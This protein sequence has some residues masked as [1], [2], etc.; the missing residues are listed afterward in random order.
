MLIILSTVLLASCAPAQVA[1]PSASTAPPAG[2]PTAAV[3]ASPVTAPVV[4][5]AASP[6]ASKVA[7]PAWPGSLDRATETL[8]ELLN[9][10]PG[11]RASLPQILQQW[12]PSSS[13]SAAPKNSLAEADLTGDGRPELV[14]GLVDP[15]AT[16]SPAGP[17]GLVIAIHDEGGR[18][19]SIP[20]PSSSTASPA[21]GPY[22]QQ[23]ADVNADG[24]AEVL[25]VSQVCGASTCTV[26][27]AVASWAGGSYRLL[28]APDL[29][30]AS[31]TVKLE[32]RDNDGRLELVLSGGLI[33]SAGAGVQRGRTEIY[34]FVGGRYE[35]AETQTE[36]TASRYLVIVDAN[37][38]F[39]RKDFRAAEPLYQ[40]AATDDALTDQR[41]SGGNPGPGLRAFARFRLLLLDAIQGKDDEARE[42]LEQMQSLDATTPYPAAAQVFWNFYGQ[43]G[44]VEAGCNQ[45]TESVRRQP[46]MLDPLNGWGYAN[47]EIK[48]DEVCKVP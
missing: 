26:F 16:A 34:R 19:R 47:A 48:A 22:V 42:I 38:A 43:T 45:F 20:I 15:G 40:R 30:M 3:A 29:N 37:A 8:V 31:A 27:P 17:R 21:A 46:A 23:V 4:S 28:T 11:A 35:L 41:P 9:A 2:S 5:P 25:T 1:V 39:D 7:A 24:A 12:N 10:N 6:V 32:D 13:N 14:V 44:S 18:F 36:P 33:G